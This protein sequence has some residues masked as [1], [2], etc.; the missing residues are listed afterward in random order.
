M[1]PTEAVDKVQEIS[2]TQ[3]DSKLEPLKEVEVTCEAS[4][5]DDGVDQVKHEKKGKVQ[6]G[7]NFNRDCLSSQLKHKL[8]E[9]DFAAPSNIDALLKSAIG[10][11]TKVLPN[12]KPFYDAIIKI[13]LVS[14]V[15]NPHK[16]KHYI[17]ASFFKI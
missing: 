11:S 17:R 7:R 13:N 16:F 4:S 15:T 3:D 2:D 12:E 1:P 5:K 9:N 8:M 10:R 14:L 6:I